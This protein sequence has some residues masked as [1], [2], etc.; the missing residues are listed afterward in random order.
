MSLPRTSGEGPHGVSVV[1]CC[2]NSAA[3][4]PETLAHLARQTV[5]ERIPWEVVVVD[6]A[7]TDGTADIA[8]E[9]WSGHG[10]H[11]RFRVVSEPQAGLVVA[12]NTGVESASFEYVLFCDDDNRLARDYVHLVWQILTEV[13]EAGVVGGWGEPS[14]AADEPAWFHRYPQYY[15]T[16][17]QAPASGDITDDKGF[18]YGAGFALRRSM[19]LDVLGLG[20]TSPLRAYAR[21][22]NDIEVCYL[23]RFAGARIWYD[24][25][26]R[27]EHFLPERRLMWSSFLDLV[28]N[29]HLT[30]VYLAAYRHVFEAWEQ[31]SPYR[32][33]PKLVWLPRFAKAWWRWLPTW[34][35]SVKHSGERWHATKVRERRFRGEWR[36]WATVR[37]EFPE[38]CDRIERVRRGLQRTATAPPR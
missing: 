24:E 14:F 4:L 13:P 18:V 12:R 2:H 22:S 31:G 11:E 30:G 38:L 10:G 16:G 21:G 29:S 19:W 27:F 25:R 32:T 28:E 35:A 6:N 3:V 5:P 1:V 17:P 20:F 36:G 34:A 7:S 15:A 8:R 33:P 37:G 9:A 26:L 23:M